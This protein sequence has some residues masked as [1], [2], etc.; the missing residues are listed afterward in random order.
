[1][2]FLHTQIKIPEHYEYISSRRYEFFIFDYVCTC[3]DH[4]LTINHY[5]VLKLT[6]T[7]WWYQAMCNVQCNVWVNGTLVIPELSDSLDSK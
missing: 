7:F 3:D 6:C 1:M 4:Y 5:S 2:L